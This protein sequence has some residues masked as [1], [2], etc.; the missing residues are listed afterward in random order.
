MSYCAR[1]PS[2]R[3]IGVPNIT[4]KEQGVCFR[5]SIAATQQHRRAKHPAWR[6]SNVGRV[7]DTIGDMRKGTNSKALNN[8]YWENVPA[9]D[10]IGRNAFPGKEFEER[11]P[12]GAR[13]LDLGCGTG[14]MSEFL[15]KRGYQV[16]GIDINTEA[17]KRNKSRKTRADYV[18]GDITKKLPF[19]KSSFDAVIISFVL[20]NVIPLK[21]REKLISEITRI[22]KNRGIVWINEGLVSPQAYSRRYR[23]SKPYM[24]DKHDFFVFKHGTSFSSVRTPGQMKQAIAD[25]EI[26]RTAHHFDMKEL[27]TLFNGYK[28]VYQNKSETSSPNTK[29][30][31][32]MVIAIFELKG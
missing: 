27:R 15:A 20:V 29:S 30:V 22:L 7:Y 23:L 14:E 24:G 4:Q 10:I 13:V 31:I 26:A 8:A 32:K 2:R 11:L 3:P 12:R 17:I 19:R 9:D 21:E 1:K 28:L 5:T 6:R 25:K 16:T 18:L